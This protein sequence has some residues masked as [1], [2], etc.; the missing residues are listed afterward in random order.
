[1]FRY[2]K[3]LSGALVPTGFRR[4]LAVAFTLVSVCLG[5]VLSVSMS[6]LSSWKVREI[7]IDEARQITAMFARQSTFALLYDSK[8]GAKI[9][10]EAILDFPGVRGLALYDSERQLLY[11]DGIDN[12]VNSDNGGHWPADLEL[13][14]ETVDAWFFVAPVYVPDSM[15][16]MGSAITDV[17]SDN[18]LIGFVRL[19]MSKDALRA[20]E[21]DILWRNLLVSFVLAGILLLVLLLVLRRVTEPLSQLAT[22]MRRARVGQE[23]VRAN[24]QGAR[25]IVAM[26]VTFNNMME[27]LEKHETELKVAR[28]AALELA[29]VKS[30]FAA[31]VSHE[32][33]TPL[34]GVLGMLELLREMGLTARQREYVEVAH[35]SG[36]SLLALIDGILDFSRIDAGKLKLEPVD[37]VLPEILDDVVQLLATQAHS[38]E[39]DLGYVIAPD[40]PPSVRGDPRCIRQVLLNLVGNALKF[41]SSGEVAVDV[42]ASRNPTGEPLLKFSVSDTGC[43]IP[44]EVQ[45]HI[46]EPFSQADGS[47]ARATGGAGLGLTISQQLVDFMGGKIEVSS[48][49]GEG[50]TFWFTIPLEL[51]DQTE[52]PAERH[53]T[54]LSGVRVLIVDDSRIGRDHL[55]YMIAR[56]GVSPS[57]AASGQDVL[58]EL[59][60]ATLE[61]RP[62]ELAIVD[63]LMPEM[64]GFQLARNIADD[65][66]ITPVRLIMM[67]F[68]QHCRISGGKSLGIVECLVKPVREPVLYETISALVQKPRIAGTIAK[69]VNSGSGEPLHR[70]AYFVLVAED[71]R[72]NQLVIQGMLERLGCR[73]DIAVNGEQ[74]VEKTK[75]KSYDLILMDCQMPSVDG[76][77]ATTSIRVQEK[78]GKHTPIIAMTANVRKRD[79][80]RCM[81]VGMDDFLPKPIKLN[82]LKSK[83]RKWL[84]GMVEGFSDA[85]D[86]RLSILDKSVL[87]ELRDNIG[88]NLAGLF[89]VFLE[90]IPVYLKTLEKSIAEDD[91]PALVQAAH[92]I[93]GSSGNVGANRLA[94][95][96][97]LLEQLGHGGS[98]T[99]SARLV[100]TLQ[101]ELTQVRAALQ[102]ELGKDQRSYPVVSMNEKSCVL[103]VDDDRGMRFA[104]RSVVESAGY[105]VEEVANGAQAI[106]FCERQIPD[107]ILVDALMPRMDGFVACQKIRRLS[108]C[109]TL[110]V[111]MVTALDDEQ[112]IEKAFQVGATDYIPKPV[113]FGLLRQRITRLLQASYTEQRMHQLAYHDSL[114]ELPNRA[115]FMEHLATVL[116]NKRA[117]ADMLALLFL[118]LDRFKLVND[119]LGHDI[120]DQLLKAAS[121]R[122]TGCVRSRDLVARLGGDEFTIILEGIGSTDEVA[123]VADKICSVLCEPFFFANREM[124][125]SASIGIAMSPANGTDVYT[126]VKRAD[127]AMFCAKKEGGNHRFYQTGMGS[128]VTKRLELESDL[129]RAL[130][131]RELELHYQ[132][133]LNL[134]TGRFSGMEVL[135][136]WSHAKHGVIPP[137][138]FIPLAEETGLIVPL[139]DYVLRSACIRT[140]QWRKQGYPA[141]RVAVNLSAIQLEKGK[142]VGRVAAILDETG[143]PAELL[144]LEITENTIMK[145]A[146]GVISVLQGLR[147]LG[148]TLAID[149]FGT[150][151]SSLSYL[152]HFPIDVLKID[153]S[154]IPNTGT[155]PSD[156]AVISSIISLAQKL[157]LTVIAEG[158]E[159]KEQQDFL[160]S[161]GCDLVQGN[162]ISQ[163]LPAAEFEQQVLRRT[164][165]GGNSVQAVS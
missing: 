22:A 105:Q 66:G 21:R 117:D 67:S 101:Q 28:D 1:M 123:R 138:E 42:H 151:Y 155:H 62:Y 152:R 4:Q 38:K 96:A 91:A 145:H 49:P 154:F 163:P 130:E 32:L 52:E 148:V 13:E 111:L 139:G 133:Q 93:R 71:N 126:L 92:A 97:R 134:D 142:L 109:R 102:K 47:T 77:A 6:S 80:Q 156:V 114:T 64:D 137:A 9:P 83:L 48:A 25:D 128:V 87:N 104:L 76:F 125:I 78:G 115:Y 68:Q 58:D 24:I 103:I 119:T 31:N 7:M 122:I 63:D 118:D 113:H 41:T 70:T 107:L 127:M 131:N 90:D 140:Q 85:E 55:R 29:S 26:G 73:V 95:V 10:I 11:S 20:M 116:Q 82:V 110:P 46:F 136:R 35:N 53:E 108:G 146:D 54:D 12:T 8:K 161:Q 5:I 23:G 74:A 72:A 69:T 159:T 120:G 144:E 19:V 143:L 132:P 51:S 61:N 75:L 106:A 149:D 50:S 79:I 112:S 162:Y 45:Q 158:V 37:F 86:S 16:N 98:T 39:L 2:I 56:W 141:M 88:D 157:R 99:N 17:G 15:K 14:Q 135:L 59:R 34:N 18:K 40:V 36:E 121:G 43:G 164:E 147:D 81:E 65:N 160:V 30:E 165:T 124:Y 33:R 129:R 100:A 44:A 89:E 57:V 84:A 27:A 60:L 94:A 3:A 150:G 153:R